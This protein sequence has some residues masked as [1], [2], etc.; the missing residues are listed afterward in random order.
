MQVVVSGQAAA[1]VI[2]SAI[3]LLGALA[4]VKYPAAGAMMMKKRGAQT[5]SAFRFFTLSTCV[6]SARAYAAWLMKPPEYQ[7]IMGRTQDAKSRSP[8]RCLRALPLMIGGLVWF[9]DNRETRRLAQSLGPLQR[10]R[11]PFPSTLSSLGYSIAVTLVRGKNGGAKSCPTHIAVR[12]LPI[13]VSS[14]LLMDPPTN[15]LI[16]SISKTH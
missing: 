3:R 14:V 4:S 16:P 8:Y 13:T 9:L 7:E 12:I 1:G 11:S 10:S 2:F 6:P 15:R 5:R